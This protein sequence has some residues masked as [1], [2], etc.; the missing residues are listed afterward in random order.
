MDVYILPPHD[1]SMSPAIYS[2][3][4]KLPTDPW[5]RAASVFDVPFSPSLCFQDEPCSSGSQ[6]EDETNGQEFIRALL[7]QI[8]DSMV[9]WTKLLIYQEEDSSEVSL[10]KQKTSLFKNPTSFNYLTV[11]RSTSCHSE[12][13]WVDMIINLSSS[14]TQK[15]FSSG[16][17]LAHYVRA[18]S[19]PDFCAPVQLTY[20]GN[21]RTS[22]SELKFLANITAL[23]HKKN[24]LLPRVWLLLTKNISLQK[25]HG[26]PHSNFCDEIRSAGTSAWIELML[27]FQ[28]L[29]ERKSWVIC[30]ARPW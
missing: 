22:G 25:Q 3:S 14:N 26:P 4:S 19:P 24:K 15:L 21:K 11:T 12:I 13:T 30:S 27:S 16:N 5:L 23:L 10:W 20:P 9:L 8:A 17:A 6:R 28:G 29:F 18:H 2:E 1:F 7:L